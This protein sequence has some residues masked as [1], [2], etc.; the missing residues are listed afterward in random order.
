MPFFLGLITVKV[1]VKVTVMPFSLNGKLRVK[2]Q[3]CRQHITMM[4]LFFF[5]KVAHYESVTLTW[6]VHS[7]LVTYRTN[8]VFEIKGFLLKKSKNYMIYKPE[9]TEVCFVQILLYIFEHFKVVMRKLHIILFI[10]MLNVSRI[11]LKK[12]LKSL[13]SRWSTRRNTSSLAPLDWWED[14]LNV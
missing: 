2:S 12:Y 8:F 10:V 6:K 14:L 7:N 13:C 1:M 11:R 3:S 4:S 9:D 5:L